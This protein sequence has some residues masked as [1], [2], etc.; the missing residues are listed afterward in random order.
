MNSVDALLQQFKKY[1][2]ILNV[3]KKALVDDLF[4]GG[5]EG[6]K[7]PLPEIKEAILHYQQAHYEIMTLAE[8]TVNLK[9]YRVNTQKMKRDLGDEAHKI[10]TKILEA[11]YAYC[12]E[13]I[14]EINRV[15]MEMS[16]KISHDPQNEKELILTREHIDAA[17]VMVEKNSILLADVYNHILMLEE[18][19]F[20]YKEHE[21]DTYW[22]MK[23][24]PMRI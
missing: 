17:P 19:S 7:K 12:N 6:G 1:E 11:T 20:M 5:E 8:N 21:I 9:I 14:G 10:K 23:V 4:K 3:D 22:Y 15:Y 16:E 18:F 13:S 24:W 2:Y